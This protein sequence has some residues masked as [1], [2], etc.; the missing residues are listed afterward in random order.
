MFHF[1]PIIQLIKI[2]KRIQFIKILYKDRLLALSYHLVV[3]KELLS[4][5]SIHKPKLAI[6][7]KLDQNLD[8]KLFGFR[9]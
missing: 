1:L 3:F 8:Q 5:S 9:T 6:A 7:M 2:V 4:S